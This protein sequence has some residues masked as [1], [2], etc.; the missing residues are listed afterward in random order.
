MGGLTIPCTKEAFI[1]LTC[2]GTGHERGR[3]YANDE[4]VGHVISNIVTCNP[5]SPI[6]NEENWG[7]FISSNCKLI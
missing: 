7:C 3:R 6:L 4:S 5:V 1:D 2:S